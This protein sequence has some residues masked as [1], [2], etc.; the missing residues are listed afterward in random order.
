MN[1]RVAFLVVAAVVALLA[2]LALFPARSHAD[3][4]AVASAVPQSQF[5]VVLLTQAEP[6]DALGSRAAPVA[7]RSAG[8]RGDGTLPSP[9]LHSLD[10]IGRPTVSVIAANE[11]PAASPSLR[12]VPRL[13]AVTVPAPPSEDRD[14]GS[15]MSMTGISSW[16]A[17]IPGGAAAGP[18]LR[19]ALG[20]GWRGSVVT[21]TGPAGSA[22][23]TLSDFMR[24]DRL[25]DLDSRSFVAVCGALSL[26]L[27]EVEVSR[28]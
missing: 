25:V 24:R 21:V 19:A 9:A 13:A 8:S 12:A 27:C 11:A 2:A 14:A 28:G 22:V 4:P 18:A 10:G 3:L 6:G 15:V 17:Y 26:G 23:V 20:A 7:P 5:S 1:R 16:Y